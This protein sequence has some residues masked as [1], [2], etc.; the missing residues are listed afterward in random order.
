MRCD[1]GF[2]SSAS[3]LKTHTHTSMIPHANQPPDCLEAT[4][5][6]QKRPH[7]GVRRRI[8]TRV[9]RRWSLRGD[10]GRRRPLSIIP[11]SI[12][13]NTRRLEIKGEADSYICLQFRLP[14]GGVR[15]CWYVLSSRGGR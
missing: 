5:L 12:F 8:G 14:E 10:G 11:I 3:T 2:S 6:G 4:V 9:S 7:L 15:R 13:M 1:G